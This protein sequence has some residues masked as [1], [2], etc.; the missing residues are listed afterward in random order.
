VIIFA[1]GFRSAIPCLDPDVFSAERGAAQLYLN[2]FPERP[3]LYVIGL[4]ETD[5]SLF[6]VVSK[7][8]ALAASVIVAQRNGTDRAGW[9]E[10]QRTGVRPDLSGGIKY[11]A[12]QRHAFYVQYDEYVHRLEKMLKRMAPPAR[13]AG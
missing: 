6:P 11:L 4:F 2:V 1:T 3:G 7:Q 12:S 13:G 9:F 5:G 8:A 10:R